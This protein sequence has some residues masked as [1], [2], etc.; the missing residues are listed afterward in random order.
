M[1]LNLI[2]GAAALALVA[3]APAAALAQAQPKAP[4]YLP[5]TAPAS[6][7][8]FTQARE[9]VQLAG[10]DRGFQGFV[11][12]MLRELNGNLTRTRP[13]LLADMNVVMNETIV[14]EFMKRTGEMTDQAARIVAASMT[15]D[16]LKQTVVFLKTPAGKKYVDMQPQVMNGVISSLDAWNRQLA[17]EMMDRVR[18]E[19][20]KKGHDL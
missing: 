4:A 18:A 9:L 2:I 1:K 3:G 17:V 13:E 12:E 5:S 15:D 11:P 20:K 14:P 6:D 16:E 8:K 7:A 19:M 10:I